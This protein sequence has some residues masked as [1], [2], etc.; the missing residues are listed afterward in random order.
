MKSKLIAIL[1]VIG[2]L[3][4]ASVACAKVEGADGVPPNTHKNYEVTID[5]FMKDKDITGTIEI[6]KGDSLTLI[7]GSNPSTG[8]S[9]T[10]KARI[11]DPGVIKQ[12][13]HEFVDPA[14]ENPL[15]GAAG[16]EV[17]TFESVKAGTAKVSVEYSR[18][19]EGGEKA[20]WT[21]ELTVTVK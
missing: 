6:N 15:P 8:F 20:E 7:L 19:W 14:S 4:V 16:Q 17:W 11:I 9:W 10:E 1:V 3:L 2:L 12:T 21:F 13:R 18:P 5:K